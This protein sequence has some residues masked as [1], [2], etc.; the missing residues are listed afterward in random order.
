MGNQ[1]PASRAAV[2]VHKIRIRGFL[3]RRESQSG[4]QIQALSDVVGLVREEGVALGS[5]VI[6]VGLA[7]HTRYEQAPGG[8]SGELE[9]QWKVRPGRRDATQVQIEG[10]TGINGRVRVQD[11]AREES[12][13]QPIQGTAL[14]GQAYFFAG[15]FE[16]RL[17]SLIRGLLDYIDA[18]IIDIVAGDDGVVAPRGNRGELGEP[19][20][21]V[22]FGGN[23]RVANL[24][25]DG[26][27]GPGQATGSRQ[28][29]GRDTGCTR[30]S[31]QSRNACER[32][33]DLVGGRTAD[34]TVGHLHSAAA[35]LVALRIVG[36]HQEVY[37]VTGRDQV[38][39]AYRV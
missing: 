33:D 27:V 3:L 31:A 15:L 32:V 22:Q 13:H 1:L 35:G 38:L 11:F 20:I 17:I 14:A 2:R 19:K 25:H 29:R 9:C 18:G 5:L 26:L 12:A 34:W 21:P 39:A 30:L 8:L 28:G 24:L 7:G 23:S 16:I 4:G 10:V 37:R 6:P 36:D